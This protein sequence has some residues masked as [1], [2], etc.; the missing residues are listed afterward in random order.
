LTY[1]LAAC[2]SSALE[3]NGARSR[4]K[5]PALEDKMQVGHSLDPNQKQMQQGYR[6]YVS[7]CVGSGYR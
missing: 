2:L 7:P 5:P 6:E 1:F 3:E 4:C